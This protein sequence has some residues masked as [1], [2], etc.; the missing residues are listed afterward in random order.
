MK[1]FTHFFAHT[2]AILGGSGA[3]IGLSSMPAAS[4]QPP[5]DIYE[6]SEGLHILVELPGVD[7][8]QLSVSVEENVLKIGGFR[9]KA[10]PAST[11]NVH[12]MEIPYGHFA[13]YVRLPSSS[14]V[15]RINAKYENGYLTIEIPRNTSNE[16]R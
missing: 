15:D 1:D 3:S 14:N 11:H 8:D 12:Q 6:C 4:W 5:I 7:K 10:V 9:P 16:R 2:Y 13:R